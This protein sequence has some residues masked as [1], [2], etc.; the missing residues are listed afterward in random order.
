MD[1]EITAEVFSYGGC[2]SCGSSLWNWLR[3]NSIKVDHKNV[4]IHYER[5][6]ATER[7]MALGVEQVYFPL[8]F[9][10]GKVVVGFK[11]QELTDII[12]EIREG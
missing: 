4:Q 9:I 3:Q 5:K 12:N 8:V 2:T 6:K 11:P 7:A 1:I 10:G